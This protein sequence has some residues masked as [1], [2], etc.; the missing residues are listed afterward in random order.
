VASNVIRPQPAP[1]QPYSVPES[2]L[3][4]SVAYAAIE[5]G[6][7]R[8]ETEKPTQTRLE[9]KEPT[10]TSLDRGFS[11]NAVNRPDSSSWEDI[12]MGSANRAV[13]ALT[14]L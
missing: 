1:P 14:I 10:P 9:T 2:E 7:D 8:E 4:W 5:D 11:C 12:D 13:G 3:R 6:W